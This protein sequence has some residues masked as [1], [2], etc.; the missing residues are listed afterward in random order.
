MIRFKS[1]KYALPVAVLLATTALSMTAA[2]AD[3]DIWWQSDDGSV[4]LWHDDS[5]GKSAVLIEHDGKYEIYFNQAVIDA[6]FDKIDNSNP[7]P[8]D[9]NNGKGTDKPDIEAMI[10]NAKGGSWSVKVNPEDSPLGGVI[11]NNGGGKGPHWNPGDDDS[12]GPGSPPNS[13]PNGGLSPQQKAAIQKELNEAA[14]QAALGEQGMYD[15]SEGGSENAPGINMHDGIKQNN[16]NGN[17]DGK[18]KST[19]D[20][21]KDPYVPK[22]EA[23]GAKPELVNPSPELKGHATA[24]KRLG[25]VKFENKGKNSGKDANSD[26]HQTLNVTSPGLLGGGNSFSNNGPAATGV[27]GGTTHGGVTT[28]A[29]H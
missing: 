22:G 1:L 16:N 4:S 13:K 25:A 6:V 12:K 19:G 7:N 11:T 29:T 17:G 18:G 2:K 20:D 26:A 5:T 3:Y 21:Y 9:P 14:R 8:D 24:K 27:A 28:R 23:L 15:G 10:K